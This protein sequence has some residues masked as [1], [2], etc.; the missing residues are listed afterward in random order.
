MLSTSYRPHWITAYVRCVYNWQLCTTYCR[1][2]GSSM[3]AKCKKN[4]FWH[5]L[6][7]LTAVPMSTR[8]STLS[9]NKH[10][11]WYLGLVPVINGCRVVDSRVWAEWMAQVCW[12]GLRVSS[13][14]A[15]ILWYT[16]IRRTGR[17]KGLIHDSSF[18]DIVSAAW[19]LSLML[20][21]F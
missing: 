20:S 17:S 8:L 21:F 12:L 11:Y 1:W 13:W 10:Q 18:V 9:K 2:H 5:G 4:S 14:M 7:T 3:T 6:H 19:V 16:F 15:L